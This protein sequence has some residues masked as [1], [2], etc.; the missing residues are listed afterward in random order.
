MASER[1]K[2]KNYTKM[3]QSDLELELEAQAGWAQGDDY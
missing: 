2:I 3:I 1:A